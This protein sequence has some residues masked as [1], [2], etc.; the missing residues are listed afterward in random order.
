VAGPAA[1]AVHDDGYVLGQA[2]GLERRIDGALLS[3]QLVDARCE[4][5]IQETRLFGAL[6]AFMPAA[7]VAFKKIKP[8]DRRRIKKWVY[9]TTSDSPPDG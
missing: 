9:R 8:E 7:L 6:A 1:V 4:G 3:R 2:L 5:R